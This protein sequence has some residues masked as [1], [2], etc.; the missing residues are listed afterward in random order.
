MAEQK[1]LRYWKEGAAVIR[2]LGGPYEYACPLCLRLFPQD[3]IKHLSLDHVPPE[4]V[5]GKLE[6]LTCKTCNNTAGAALDAHASSVDRFRRVLAG[7]P[8]PPLLAQFKFD[9]VTANME[10]RSDRARCVKVFGLPECNPP[11]VLEEVG[12]VFEEHV[13]AGTTPS[14]QF[15]MPKLRPVERRARVS[16]LRA[17]YLAAFAV[18][19]YAAVARPSF[20]R[21]R[22]QIGDPD[23]EHLR[24]FFYRH[25]DIQGYWV[26]MVKEPKWHASLSVMMG[27]YRITLPLFGDAGIYERIAEEAALGAQAELR[28]HS[29]GWPDWPSYSCDRQLARSGGSV[30]IERR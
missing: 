4:S 13:R 10:L 24:H 30:S 2:E 12:E 3:Q 19:G 18:I 11:G 16:Y 27:S 26:G 23:T 25:G 29:L 1:R 9:G 21:V 5:G 6:I 17:G 14:I 15:T 8:Y 20:D 22:R 28:F 7:E